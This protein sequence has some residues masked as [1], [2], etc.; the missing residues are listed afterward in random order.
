MD[1]SKYL[2]EDNPLSDLL[3]LLE[4]PG[5]K[6]FF[7]TEQEVIDSLPQNRR[8]AERLMEYLKEFSS[9]AAWH[10]L[11]NNFWGQLSEDEQHMVKAAAYETVE[12]SVVDDWLFSVRKEE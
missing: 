12:K 7:E 4:L 10:A 5:T 3:E 2:N 8:S 9:I 1:I 6:T 11:I